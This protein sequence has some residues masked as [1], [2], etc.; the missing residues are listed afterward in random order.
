MRRL[1][2]SA[3]NIN[4]RIL[5]INE[6]TGEVLADSESQLVGQNL[7]SLGQTSHLNNTLVGDFEYQSV[8]WLFSTRQGLDRTGGKI[9]V[10]ALTEFD[11]GPAFRDPIFQELLRPLVIAGLLALIVSIVLAVIITRSVTH[12]FTAYGGGRAA[13]RQR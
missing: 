7:L 13:R 3:A 9:E 2:N 5:L 1:Q 8:R 6:Q 4:G 10:V 11:P 12:A